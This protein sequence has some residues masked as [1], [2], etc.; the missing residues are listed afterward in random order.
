[1]EGAEGPNRMGETRAF[2]NRTRP[3]LHD[4]NNAPLSE[5]YDP[6]EIATDRI[7]GSATTIGHAHDTTCLGAQ[8]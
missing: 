3:I 2:S 7:Y 4:S 6:S 8:I 5:D 1:M